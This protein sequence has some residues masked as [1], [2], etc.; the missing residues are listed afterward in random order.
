MI[1]ALCVAPAATAAEPAIQYHADMRLFTINTDNTTYAMKVDD[2]GYLIHLFWGGKLDR[3]QDLPAGPYRI[4]PSFRDRD[5]RINLNE[6][7]AGW[8]GILFD[9]PA[10][11]ATFADKVRDLVLKYE[12]YSIQATPGGKTLT[13]TLKDS[14]YPFRVHLNYRTYQD[15]D[16]IDRNAI[17]ENVGSDPV[18]LE[19]V[20]SGTWYVPRSPR[21]RLTYMYGKWSGECQLE[22]VML[23]QSK[24]VLENRRGL[25]GHDSTPWF[26]LDLDGAATEEHG[27]V[28]FGALQWSG[29]WKITAETDRLQQAR[30]TGGFGDYD[31]S[32]NLK[33]GEKLETPVFTGGYTDGGFGAMS[34]MLHRYQLDHLIPRAKAYKELPVGYNSWGAFRF[35]IN[36]GQQMVLAEKAAKIGA[37]VFVVD[38][39]WFSTRDDDTSGLGDWYPSKTKFPRGLK[40][41][42]DKVNS[43]GMRFGLW[44]EPEMVNP[45]SELYQ[46]HPDWVLHFPNRERTTGRNQLVLN[47]AREDVKQFAFDVVDQLLGTL[48]I[49]YLKWDMNRYFSEPG[50]PSEAGPEQKEVSVKYVFNLYDIWD[51]LQKKYP[52]VI[53][54]NCASGGGRIDLGMF[55]YT[56]W[57][58]LTDN[59][60]PIDRLKIMHGYSMAYLPKITGTGLA[61]AKVGV[62]GRT[63]SLSFRAHAGFRGGALGI[64]GNLLEYGDQELAE[65][66]KYVAYFKEIR[67]IVSFGD[68]YRLA[69]PYEG[70]YAAYE[71]VSRDKKAAVLIVLGQWMQFNN[72]LPRIALRGLDPAKVYEVENYGH[73]SGKGLMEV[74]IETELVG[75]YDSKVFKLKAVD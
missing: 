13:I 2:D 59:T 41:L 67:P 51:R 39:G 40:P 35:A 70:P 42:I 29:N 9:E 75:D 36:E 33:A 15:L 52:D 66:A 17:I 53:F 63:Y 23:G 32:W 43:L 69:S 14:F 22:Q 10:L 25:S 72:S 37:E 65:I 18:T 19:S 26:A 62:S 11:K 64:G 58:S 68:L 48:N 56:D 6:E 57:Q 50:W 7:Y 8:G 30:V 71:Y 44:V 27:K 60:D 45:K 74:G 28:W 3:P 49:K 16:I 55:R 47:L 61:G 24:T 38:D 4:A 5:K 20:M 1:A 73:M 12:N 34:R 54:H 46:K 31:F 21:Y